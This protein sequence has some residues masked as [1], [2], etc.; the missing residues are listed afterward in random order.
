VNKIDD[1]LII[2][3]GGTFSKV[4]DEVKGK[5]IIPKSSKNLKAIILKAFKSKIKIKGMIYK[6]SLEFTHKY[7]EKL[8]LAIQKTKYNKIIIIHGTDT[9]DISAK[10]ISEKISD[11]IIIFTGAMMPVSIDVTEGISNLSM[12]I[13][14]LN[15]TY[16]KNGIYISMHGYVKRYDEIRK[17]KDIGIFEI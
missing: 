9:M 15:A 4:Y 16:I 3:T 2:N 6:D 12:A 13:G 10:Y 5:L 1:I 17:N 11:K 8:Y 7:R 14:F